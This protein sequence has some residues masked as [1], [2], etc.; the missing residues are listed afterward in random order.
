VPVYQWALPEDTGPLAEALEQLIE[1]RFACVMFTT[2]VQVDHVL[3]FAQ[4]QGRRAEV[5][6]ALKKTFIAS[7]GPT[8]SESLR[9]VGL[10]PTLEPSHPKMGVLVREAALANWGGADLLVCG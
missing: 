9:A 1:G 2:G 6:D 10:T 8:C 5:L 3:E 7:I 4:Q